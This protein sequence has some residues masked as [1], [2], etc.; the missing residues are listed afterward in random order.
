MRWKTAKL[1]SILVKGSIGAR[2]VNKGGVRQIELFYIRDFLHSILPLP[3]IERHLSSVL[4]WFH[5]EAYHRK[6]QG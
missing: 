5:K 4:F 3:L 1:G 2:A 6:D